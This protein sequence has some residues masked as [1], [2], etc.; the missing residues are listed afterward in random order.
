MTALTPLLTLLVTTGL[1]QA[2]AA[3]GGRA[4]EVGALG[5]VLAAVLAIASPGWGVEQRA[6]AGFVLDP[7]ALTATIAGCLLALVAL[8]LQRDAARAPVA[9]L[10]AMATALL[11]TSSHFGALALG[12]ATFT[13]TVTTL[14]AA[15]RGALS[16]ARRGGA[17]LDVL[18][19]SL[20]AGG[21]LLFGVALA[22][23]QLGK[24]STEAI[25]TTGIGLA[26][27]SLVVGGGVGLL[28]GAPLS[29][30]LPD[31]W[32]GTAASALLTGGALRLGVVATLVRLLGA[33]SP[34]VQTALYAL[35]A[36][37]LVGSFVAPA[38][39]AGRVGLARHADVYL[40]LSLGGELSREATVLWLIADTLGTITLL[41]A[42]GPGRMA[43]Q[44][45][46]IASLA[47]ALPGV[48]LVAR[49][50]I[51]E[52]AGTPLA[53]ALVLGAALATLWHGRVVLQASEEDPRRR[54]I[55]GAA[56]VA[57]VALGI[58]PSWWTSW[59]VLLVR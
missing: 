47:G 20:A 43:V 3:R 55:A 56:A 25:R 52:G 59:V 8:A 30:W 22:Y 26:A 49:R 19:S 54:W 17:P 39:V 15:R 31:P 41:A 1:T 46:A 45:V 40:L 7:L 2:A 33:P 4:R 21:A 38:G 24:L 10:A 12:L 34:E 53:R 48:G 16:A 9:P 14:S 27:A 35:A 44:A 13:L 28:G 6:D 42:S 36:V 32:A 11:A 29:R 50:A 23:A 5:L 18:T 58:M 51:Y 57:V 37:A